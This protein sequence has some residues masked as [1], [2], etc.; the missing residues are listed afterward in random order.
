MHTT[1]Q[2]FKQKILTAVTVPNIFTQSQC[3]MIIRDAEVIGMKRAPVMAK[4]GSFVNYR[5]RTCDSCWLPKAAHFGWIYNYLAAVVDQVNTEHYR[6]DVMDMQNLQ[7]LRYRPL[8][9]FD[10]HFDTFDG[11]DRKLTCVVNLSR[12]EEY[13]GGGL[14]VAGDWHNSDKSTHQGSANFF[15]T[16]IKHKAR[17]PIWGTRWALVAWITGPAWK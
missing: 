4:D 9:K 11:S 15:P 8:Q 5:T 2:A 7:I 6:F 3:E 14:R 10:W 13:I 12:P 16:W 1:N 17:A